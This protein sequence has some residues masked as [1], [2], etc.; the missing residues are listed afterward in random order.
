MQKLLNALYYKESRELGAASV[1]HAVPGCRQ[2]CM[3][4]DWPPHHTPGQECPNCCQVLWLLTSISWCPSMPTVEWKLGSH[5]YVNGMESQSINNRFYAS[6]LSPYHYTFFPL[7][8]RFIKTG[9]V[10]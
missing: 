7:P 6:R 10:L 5:V 9:S 2:S 8:P 3:K 4:L 1:R